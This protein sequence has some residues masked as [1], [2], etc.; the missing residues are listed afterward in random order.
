[1]QLGKAIK[2]GLVIFLIKLF[3]GILKVILET[4]RFFNKTVLLCQAVT[5]VLGE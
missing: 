2:K 5:Q 1:M 3:Q 4:P